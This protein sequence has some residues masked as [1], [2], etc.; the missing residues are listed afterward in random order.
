MARYAALL[1][2]TIAVSFEEIAGSGIF[3][4]KVRGQPNGFGRHANECLV[5]GLIDQTP[6]LLGR[7]L[8]PE[9]FWFEHPRPADVS[10]LVACLRTDAISFGAPA[11]GFSVSAKVLDLPIATSDPALLTVLDRY[12]SQSLE[13]ASTF[14]EEARAALRRQL[15]AN[16]QAPTLASTA[17]SLGVGTRTLQRRLAAEGTGFSQA[18]DAVRADLANLY[19]T[20]GTHTL[21]EIAF[22]L[23][24]TELSPFTRAFKRWTGMAPSAYRERRAK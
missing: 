3:E 22:L 17:A 8:E 20:R 15:K 21:S 13:P 6:S 10:E 12:A 2:K 23:G 19:V 1:S 5:C 11:N 16:P 4:F 14:A 24:Y 7:S 9:R 18:L